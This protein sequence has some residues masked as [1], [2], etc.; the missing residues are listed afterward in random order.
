MA[1]SDLSESLQSLQNIIDL[2]AGNHDSYNKNFSTNTLKLVETG[3]SLRS[4]NKDGAKSWMSANFKQS[5]TLPKL[6]ENFHLALDELETQIILSKAHLSRDLDNLRSNRF[7]PENSTHHVEG[8]PTNFDVLNEGVNSENVNMRGCVPEIEVEV[9][10]NKTETH[11]RNQD[12]KLSP[13]LVISEPI[14]IKTKQELIR[15]KSMPAQSNFEIQAATE[16]HALAIKTLPE[17]DSSLKMGTSVSQNPSIDSLFDLPTDKKP[18][19]NSTTNLGNMIDNFEDFNR[20]T[21]DFNQAQNANLSPFE[22][23]NILKESS[24]I[25]LDN[26]GI[27]TPSTNAKQSLDFSGNQNT[28][29]ENNL[30]HINFDVITGI[31]D[32]VFDGAFFGDPK[33]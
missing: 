26:L 32:C 27:F 5:I 13:N 11:P 25:D 8:Q 2:V 29:S 4:H 22:Q 33:H 10:E 31:D 30:S 23:E 28:S 17:E 9:L 3:K 24:I 6:T 7:A 18:N 20:Q 15:N 16:S 12:L 19:T 1:E 14:D 21:Q